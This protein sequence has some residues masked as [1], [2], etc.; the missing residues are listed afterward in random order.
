[1]ESLSGDYLASDDSSKKTTHFPP[2]FHPLQHAVPVSFTTD[3]VILHTK[4]QRNIKCFSFYRHFT[5]AEF[6]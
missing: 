5:I 3:R 2:P 6:S 1:M 4:T